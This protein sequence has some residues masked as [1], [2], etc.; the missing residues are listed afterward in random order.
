MVFVSETKCGEKTINKIK[1]SCKFEGCLMVK[2][3]GVSGGLCLL[4]KD[5]EMV[6]IR[7]YSNNH[8]DAQVKW[9]DKT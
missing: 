4:W 8:I 7:S 6:G 2:S 5:S 9:K 1:V 3:N